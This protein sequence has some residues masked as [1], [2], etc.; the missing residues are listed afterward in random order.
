MKHASTYRW[1]AAA[2]TFALI[3]LAGCSARQRAVEAERGLR[4]VSWG[5]EQS[6]VN[7]GGDR[8]LTLAEALREVS[9]MFGTPIMATPDVPNDRDV[10]P[11]EFV[12]AT[13]VEAALESLLQPRGVAYVSSGRG[14]FLVPVEDG[15]T[16]STAKLTPKD[17]IRSAGET[18]ATAAAPTDH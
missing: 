11:G 17:V 18:T 4:Y 2:L 5:Q 14:V 8:L 10:T 3:L 12:D 13:D 15:L 16:L 1:T 7:L 9:A 6:P